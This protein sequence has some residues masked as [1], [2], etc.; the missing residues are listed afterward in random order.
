M[1]SCVLMGEIIKA[2][3]LRFTQDGQTAI[4]EMTVQFPAIRAEDPMETVKV[5]S[6]GNMAQQV[7][8]QYQQGDQVVIEGR[9]TMNSIDRPEGFKEKVAEIT[10][11]RI[12]PMSMNAVTTSVP[13]MP[14]TASQG[15]SAPPAV[16]QTAPPQAAP[17]AAPPVEEPNYD[18]IPF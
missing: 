4:A 11:S 16:A 9:L 17:Q 6:W 7:Q 2:P 10:A 12:H 15:R 14:T 13:S 5:V 18:D 1:N 3:E 8:E